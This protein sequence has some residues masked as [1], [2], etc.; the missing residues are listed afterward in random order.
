MIKEIFPAEPAVGN[1]AALYGP[2]HEMW[3]ELCGRY[4]KVTACDSMWR[5]SRLRRPRDPEQGWKLHIPAT[6]LTAGRVLETVAPFL[7][8]RG[9]LFK[10]PNTL[11]ELEKLNSGVYYGYSQV[12]KFITVYPRSAREAASLARE[13]HKMTRGI[14]SPSVPFDRKFAPDSRVF[15]RYG[16]F[17]PH[18]LINPNGTPTP[19]LRGPEGDLVP[20]VR[21]HPEAKPEWVP[22]LLHAHPAPPAEKAGRAVVTP[23]STRFR[24]FRALT[25]RGRGGVYQA[26]DLGAASPRF[27]VLKEGRR[28][29]ETGWDGRDGFWRVEHEGRVL[30]ALGEAGV[31]VP[32]VYL[33][34][35]AEKNYFIAIEFVEGEN[36]QAWLCAKKRRIAVPHAVDLGRRLALL[37][38]KIHAAGW[39]WRDCKPTNLMLTTGGEL[40]PLDFEGAC[41]T[42][43]ADPLP[44]GTPSYAPPEWGDVPRERG[45][46]PEDLYALGALIYYLLTGATPDATPTLPIKTL[47]RNVPEEVC[48]VVNELLDANPTRRPTASDA[49]RRLGSA[50]PD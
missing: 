42:D 32:R 19:A 6:V 22:D 34:F 14:A 50:I 43:S 29:G 24:A 25:Q 5:Y 18:E 39:V 27:C 21:E 12:G 33:S 36:L 38:A 45:R 41:P 13:L 44:W 48:A 35:R 4:L 8:R 20:D 1:S 37:I 31:R 7:H 11:L 17:Y 49:A 15:Y 47:R 16:S 40:R 46:L 28:D 26:I 3:K 9:V 30:R 23:L 2:L 10:A